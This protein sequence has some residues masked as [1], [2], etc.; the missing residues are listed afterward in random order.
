MGYD[1]SDYR[2]IYPPYGTLQDHQDLIDGLHERG[3]VILTTSFFP[4]H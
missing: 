4:H 2:D 1:I 3:C